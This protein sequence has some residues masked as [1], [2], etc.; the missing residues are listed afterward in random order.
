[1]IM[2][3]NNNND[4]LFRSIKGFADYELEV[5]EHW[6]LVNAIV[7][8]GQEDNLSGHP[9][10]WCKGEDPEIEIYELDTGNGVVNDWLNNQEKLGNVYLGMVVEALV[11]ELESKG[12]LYD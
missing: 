8:K 1:M 10:S 6:V 12:E 5:D 9:D 4:C 7:T 3:N 11:N 2:T